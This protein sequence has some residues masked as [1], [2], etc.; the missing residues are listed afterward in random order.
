M[1][2]ARGRPECR[3][4]RSSGAACGAGYSRPFSKLSS[5]WLAASPMTPG[6]SHHADPSPPSRR[7]PPPTAQSR[8]GAE[9]AHVAGGKDALVDPSER[10]HAKIAP[11][12]AASSRAGL[13]ET[14][15]PQAEIETPGAPPGLPPSPRRSPAPAHRRI[16]MPARRRP[17]WSSTVRWRP[18][19][20]ARMSMVSSVQMPFASALPA[21]RRRS[22]REHLREQRQ[23]GGGPG[24]AHGPSSPL[25]LAAARSSASGG[26]APG[27]APRPSLPEPSTTS[28]VPGDLDH[29]VVAE[30]QQHGAAAS[31]HRDLK[32]GRR[33]RNP[34]PPTSPIA[35]PALSTTG[36]PTRSAADL[37]LVT[38][39]AAAPR[40]R[41]GACGP[42]AV[43]RRRGRRR[44]RC[45]R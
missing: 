42:S 36:R 25:S 15:P 22:G 38:R 13:R 10:P 9:F 11:G 5:A 19:R 23:R 35:A 20:K 40:A 30:R 44:P 41:P 1:A 21:S 37:V 24:R 12:P 32:A 43:R 27:T 26:A 29:H 4:P 7:V 18:P 33:R 8:R 28:P 17:A 16:T 2:A 34:A 31:G 14:R 39:P 6:S 45:R 3:T